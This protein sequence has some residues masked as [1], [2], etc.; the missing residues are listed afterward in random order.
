MFVSDNTD[1]IIDTNGYYAP[2]IG[3]T[4]AQGNAGA[5][6]LSFAG[7]SGAG[8]FSSGAGALNV[9]TVRHGSCRKNLHAVS[10]IYK[11]SRHS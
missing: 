8:I 4:L 7:D 3:I 10:F 1:L 9:A 2:Q 6:S 5:R 11:N